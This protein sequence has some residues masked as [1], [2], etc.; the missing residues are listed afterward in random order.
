MAD[1]PGYGP[2]VVAAF[3][4]LLGIGRCFPDVPPDDFAR[5]PQ[6]VVYQKVGGV[7]I[8]LTEGNLADKRNARVQ[9]TLWAKDPATRE[10]MA[11]QLMAAAARHPSME[12]LTETV[13][14]RDAALNLYSARFD[15]SVWYP[16]L[17]T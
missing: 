14:G 4:P 3:A 16:R 12:P 8:Y 10:I 13:D 1:T 15:V 2:L 11:D 17:T 9:V 6:F 5:H 7:P